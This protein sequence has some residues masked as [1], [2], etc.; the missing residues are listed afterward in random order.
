S[1]RRRHTRLVSD[2]SSDVCSSDLIATWTATDL[3]LADLPRLQVT[4]EADAELVVEGVI[5]RGGMG[6][7]QLARQ[8]ALDREVA[9]KRPRPERSEERRGGKECR[10]RWSPER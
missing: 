2:W 8:R 6:V 3:T 10:E 9:V 5:G 4:S 7:V 1:S